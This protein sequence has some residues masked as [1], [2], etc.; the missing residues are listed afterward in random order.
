[1][2]FYR[3]KI[4]SITTFLVVGF[5][6][7]PAK[8]DNANPPKII[9]L[10][11]VSNG[12]YKPGDLVTYKVI[13]TGGNPGLKKIKVSFL[14]GCFQGFD[15]NESD[16][17]KDKH[18]DSIVSA[19]VPTC[20]PGIYNPASIYILDKTGLSNIQY[21]ANSS[22]TLNP[23]SLVIS[24]YVYKPVNVGEVSPTTLQS[25]KLD[26]LSIPSN[27][28][29]GDNLILPAVT[30]VGMPVYYDTA[31]DVCS[32]NQERFGVSVM[33]GGSLK[34]NNFGKCQLSIYADNGTRFSNQKPTFS[35]PVIDSRVAVNISGNISLA[36][37]EIRDASKANQ[38]NKVLVC[39][40]GKLVKKINGIN[41]KCPSG[42]KKA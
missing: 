31:G 36:I 3:A 15:W 5:L 20:P 16:G 25:H 13:Y 32:I 26:I 19:P 27:P 30:S 11:Q 42:Y 18:G 22:R 2:R 17:I 41:P 34:F 4:V 35:Q 23:Q 21:G 38:V 8:A 40:K 9:D 6:G 12:P 7:T 39:K 24:D 28:K 10:V 37:F 14:S 1:M 33:P 29:V